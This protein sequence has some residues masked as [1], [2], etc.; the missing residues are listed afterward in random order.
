[1][2]ST[3]T[4][5]STQWKLC[6]FVPLFVR[7][8]D[9]VTTNLK[10]SWTFYGAQRLAK[11]IVEREVKVGPPAYKQQRGGKVPWIDESNLVS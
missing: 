8:S 4:C 11:A 10:D 7:L 3:L 5:R 6:L 9:E 2:L 1:M